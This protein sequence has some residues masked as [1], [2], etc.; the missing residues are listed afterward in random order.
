MN[1]LRSELAKCKDIALRDDVIA[2][3]TLICPVPNEQKEPTP[4]SRATL[5]LLLRVQRQDP[6]GQE[7]MLSVGVFNFLAK[8][9]SF[10]GI[11]SR[12]RLFAPPNRLRH[13]LLKCQIAAAYQ[14]I[15]LETPTYELDHL[16]AVF[17]ERAPPH[18]ISRMMLA[19]SEDFLYG[20]SSIARHLARLVRDTDLLGC[21]FFESA[22]VEQW[23]DF[24]SYELEPMCVVLTLTPSDYPDRDAH[25]EEA[26]KLLGVLDRFLLDRTYFVGDSIT[27]ADICI[28]SAL[29]EPYE[30]VMSA[31]FLE[32]FPNVR[33]WFDTCIHQK[34]FAAVLGE[35]RQ[36]TVAVPRANANAKAGK[37]DHKGK[38]AKEK[39]GK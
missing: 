13:D 24:S 29:V 15:P 27:L 28:T 10:S 38:A 35:L 2:N 7:I 39:K 18:D 30:Q 5:D 3:K 9:I 1:S 21:T 8:T 11:A 12:P 16:Y 31:E 37:P 6:N 23:V 34:P 36:Y 17:G 19:T 22:L 32:P 33:R 14:G 4:P 26:K 25:V 20:A